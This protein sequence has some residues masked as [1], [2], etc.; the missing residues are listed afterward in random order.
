MEAEDRADLSW[1]VEYQTALTVVVSP[2]SLKRNT[3]LLRGNIMDTTIKTARTNNLN[4]RDYELKRDV[5][6]GQEC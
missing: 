5:R 2:T 1:K 6:S 3:S 4:S